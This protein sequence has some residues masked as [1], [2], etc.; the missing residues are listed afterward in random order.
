MKWIFQQTPWLEQFLRAASFEN[1]LE[2]FLRRRRLE[3]TPHAA[4]RG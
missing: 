2:T 4:C 3:K 1:V